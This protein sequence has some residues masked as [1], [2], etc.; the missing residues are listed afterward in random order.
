MTFDSFRAVFVDAY[1]SNV[2]K[3]EQILTVDRFAPLS[4]LGIDSILMLSIS[5]DLCE[6]YGTPDRADQEGYFP[7][8]RNEKLCVDDF[9]MWVLKYGKN[10][11]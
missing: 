7:I 8:A 4:D 3:S 6:E 2:K 1:N 9:Y 5:F 10:V 11:H